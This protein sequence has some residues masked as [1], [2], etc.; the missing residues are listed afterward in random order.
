M[1]VQNEAEAKQCMAARCSGMALRSC[2]QA[3]RREAKPSMGLARQ[4]DAKAE[5]GKGLAEQH[6]PL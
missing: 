5:Q 3:K 4:Y 1:A 6:K 2:A